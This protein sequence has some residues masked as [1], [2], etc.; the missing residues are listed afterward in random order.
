MAGANKGSKEQPRR[1]KPERV[2]KSTKA[3]CDTGKRRKRELCR[4]H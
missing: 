3:G 1:G 2:P 4:S